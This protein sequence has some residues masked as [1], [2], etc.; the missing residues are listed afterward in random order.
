LVGRALEEALQRAPGLRVERVV[1]LVEV[2]LRDG[3]VGVDDPAV[4]D[5]V[6]RVRREL[7]VHVAV[8]QAGLRELA[9]LG[10]GSLTEGS[11]VAVDRELDLGM[12]VVGDLDPLHRADGHAAH[13]HGVALDEL[14]GIQEARLDPVAAGDSAAEQDQAHEHDR[15]DQRAD[16]GNASDSA[17][18]SQLPL[19]P[20][21]SPAPRPPN[22][23]APKPGTELNR[24]LLQS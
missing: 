4:G 8:G 16:G 19:T 12:A 22:D 23:E 24:E 10:A 17:Q 15:S 21:A 3:P 11:V 6:V 1:E 18:R 9:D 5:R 20:L 7:Q 2:D 14:A 13:L